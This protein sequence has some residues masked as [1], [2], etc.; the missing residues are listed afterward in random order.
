[1]DE[2][3]AAGAAFVP[4]AGEEIEKRLLEAAL[5]AELA[6]ERGD[7]AALREIVPAGA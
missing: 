6:L 2:R 5:R 4:D 1:M 7:E 3:C